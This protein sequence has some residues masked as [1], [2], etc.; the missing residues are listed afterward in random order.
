M[1]KNFPYTESEF[2]KIASRFNKNLKVHF[3]NLQG[4]SAELDSDFVFRFKAA[5]FKSRIH[6]VH[7]EPDLF[8]QK[9]HDE[10]GIL[11]KA[12]QNLFQ[13][14][15]YYIQKAFPYD[16][17]L[18]EPF[19]YCEVENA[20]H[21]YEKLLHCLEEFIKMIKSKKHELLAVK[22]PEESF[23]EI[24]DLFRKIVEKHDEIQK[25]NSTKVAARESHINSL[26]KLYK[27]MQLV[28]NSAVARFKDDPQTL[29][30][31][32]LPVPEK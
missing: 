13:N 2:L 19:G 12:A 31:L 9:I 18:W 4:F 16:S 11:I 22:C 7:Q 17:T 23:I 3:H 14:F 25:S 6:P 21:D 8:T 20:T 30:K 10:L 32:T 27:L 15:R 26:N 28:H 1:P 5:F 29:E 24:E